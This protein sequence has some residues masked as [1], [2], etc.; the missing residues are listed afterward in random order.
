VR[1]A[2]RE[3]RPQLCV[4]PSRGSVKEGGVRVPDAVPRLLGLR[5]LAALACGL[6]LG[7]AFP[8]YGLW[9]LALGA[10]A[11]ISLLTRGCSPGGGAAIGF[12]AGATFFL[13]LLDWMRVIGPDA[14][15]L[16]AALE[17]SFCAL[18]GAG[19]AATSRLGAWPVWQA[20]LWVA[21]EALRARLPFGGLPWGRL[22]F[23]VVDTPYVS[24]AG[25]GG[26]PLVTFAVAL[27]GTLLAAAVRTARRG[28]L[29]RSL[30]GAVAVGLLGLAVPRPDVAPSGTEQSLTAAVVQGNV[31]RIGMDFLGQREAVL[32]NHVRATER[33]ADLVARGELPRPDVV[34]WPE[35]A[36]DIDPYADASARDLISDAVDAA[37]VPTL[38]G[39]VA[40][41]PGPDHVRNMGIVWTPGHGPGQTY[42]KRHPVPF[43]EYV[44][45]RRFLESWISRL[46]RIPRD[47]AA[48][49]RVGALDLGPARV[50]DLICFEI[51]YDGLVRDVIDAG[52]RLL[53]VQTNN[54]T[55]GRTGQPEQQLA[56]SRLRAVEHGRAVLVAAT[57]GISAVIRPDGG[58]AHRSRE[59]TADLLVDRVPLRDARTPATRVGVWPEIL[60][61]LAGAAGALVGARRG[62]AWRRAADTVNQPGNPSA[63]P[64]GRAR[65]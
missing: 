17:A 43:G 28:R 23:G 64:T 62:R 8:P 30:A 1:P 46:D 50:G 49:D 35:N 27:S 58:V 6:L 24:Y 26:A 37:G 57:S 48:G 39:A 45:F 61:A 60:L 18:L 4:V 10:V 5:F 15:V 56:I 38:V 14:W 25:L 55:Y 63:E 51:A 20:L 34:I 2:A 59:F 13:V 54:A 21:V 53:V 31:P 16:L 42:V 41:G 22:A 40:E 7:L 11:G 65:T 47:F 19:L 44:P 29:P 12:G 32:R 33:L 9:P 3:R 36:S 52:G